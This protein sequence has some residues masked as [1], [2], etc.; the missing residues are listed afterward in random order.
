[1]M[2]F[3]KHL[4]KNTALWVALMSMIP[5]TGFASVNGVDASTNKRG[6]VNLDGSVSI[7]DVTDLVNIILNNAEDLGNSDVNN[8]TEVTVADVTVLVD[9]IVNG[10]GDDTVFDVETNVEIGYGGAGSGPAHIIAK[11]KNKAE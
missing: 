1:M 4:K 2:N 10:G 11:P 7:T 9:L 6:D 3:K 8:D 5:F